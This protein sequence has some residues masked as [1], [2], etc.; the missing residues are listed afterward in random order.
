MAKYIFMAVLMYYLVELRC[1]SMVHGLLYVMNVRMIMMLEPSVNNW[2]TL[3]MVN[4]Q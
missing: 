1:V 4:L 2:V 3:L